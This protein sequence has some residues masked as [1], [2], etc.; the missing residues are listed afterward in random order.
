MASDAPHG[1]LDGQISQADAL[2][3]WESIAATV[4]GMLGGYPHI[5]HIDIRGSLNFIQKLRRLTSSSS[6]DRFTRGV[7][8]G[9]G[10]GRIT[11]GLLS[12][13]CDI[14]DVV[15]PIGKFAKEAQ[16]AKLAGKGKIGEVYVLS[17]QDWEPK[18]EYDLA[19]NQWCL[20][21]L[22]DTEL[23]KYLRKCRGMVKEGGWIIVKENMSTDPE[24]KDIFDEVDSS[25][26]RADMKF[27]ALFEKSGL[28]IAKTE[29]QSGFPKKLYPVRFYALQPEPDQSDHLS[30]GL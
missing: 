17:L 25:V 24:G 10:I 26:T 12:K 15:E 14:V 30:Q 7:D 5:S 18:E 11:A 2:A 13:V 9:A 16:A 1:E 6:S 3:Y 28:V 27:R 20:G 19:W 8:C 23:I 4:N 22:T 29:L 21:H